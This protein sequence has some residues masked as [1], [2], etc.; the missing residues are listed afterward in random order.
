M[1][2]LAAILVVLLIAGT[3]L[4]A[5]AEAGTYGK[6]KAIIKKAVSRRT[7]VKTPTA[8]CAVRG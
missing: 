7:S 4:T 1:G 8:V 2:K 6:V 3:I 5:A